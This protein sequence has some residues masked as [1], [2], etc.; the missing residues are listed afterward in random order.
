MFKIIPQSIILR[1]T[2]K[3]WFSYYNSPYYNIDVSAPSGLAINVPLSLSV[4]SEI[5][6]LA[7]VVEKCV[8]SSRSR[9]NSY[10]VSLMNMQINI[11][12]SQA[13]LVILYTQIVQRYNTLPQKCLLFFQHSVIHH[14]HR[15]P[16]I[17]SSAS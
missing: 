1:Q 9:R 2:G 13:T 3:N 4:S 11:N 7:F 6:N 12:N 17:F 10:S 5:S 14:R 15:S 16:P 8:S